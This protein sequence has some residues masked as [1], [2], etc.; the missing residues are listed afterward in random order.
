MKPRFYLGCGIVLV[1]SFL[2]AGCATSNRLNARAS[3]GEMAGLAAAPGPPRLSEDEIDRR[4]RSAAHFATGLSH[5]LNQRSDL[6]L[7]QYL[8]SIE[9]HPGYEP[10]V[11]EVARRMLQAN[12]PEKAIE[13]L[14]RGKNAGLDS[15]RIDAWLGLA[16]AQAGKM[17]QAIAANRRAIQ[18]MP[19]NLSGYQNLA[20]L[21]SQ[22]NRQTEALKVLD[23]AAEQPDVDAR[24]LLDLSDIFFRI[25]G[26]Q[27]MQPDLIQ[28]RIMRL[29]ERVEGMAPRELEYQL[30][31]ADG[32][33]LTG[34]TEKAENL[35]LELL[36]LDPE[37]PT[38]QEKLADIYL[39]TG[40]LEEAAERFKAISRENPTDP[41]PYVFLA[42]LAMEAS[43]YE[44]A[45]EYLEKALLLN[46]E[47]EQAYYE[48]ARLYL[49][50]EKPQEAL[51]WLEKARENFSLNFPLEFFTAISQSI[52]ENYSA[53][54]QHFTSAEILAQTEAP[55]ILNA[56]FHFQ[57]GATYERHGDHEAAAQQF[58]KAL[59]LAPD[60]PEALNY[61]G[62]MW[63]DLGIHLEEAHDLIE[64]AVEI[65]PEN[66]AYLDSLGW[67]LF[68]LERT[69]EALDYILK[70]IE[71]SEKPDP[72]LYDHL[73]DIYAAL[74]KHE[75][76]RDAWK[77]SLNLEPNEHAQK[78]RGKLEALEELELAPE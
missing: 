76:A 43:K 32:F 28:P 40:R 60:F 22:N 39:R 3:S 24:F 18:K 5:D 47:M 49:S 2:L 42:S 9:A 34:Q 11:L 52:L 23:Q 61:L 62:Y 30:R 44:E 58:K 77:D 57:F 46:P 66:A 31:L 64:K 56:Q 78:I 72:V 27:L 29:L 50:L 37:I 71:L 41:Q 8:H 63:A 48:L 65:E 35:Y 10:V 67:V 4:S 74:G 69:E 15:G 75:E 45:A 51:E 54:V 1:S 68:R 38:L 12:N 20:H 33:L 55:E 16:H 36:E 73:G 21:Y 6:A 53:A 14:N 59:K 7:Q 17:D 13:I 70:A 25:I 26:M 19:G